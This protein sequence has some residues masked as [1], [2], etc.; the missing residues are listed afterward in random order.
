MSLKQ[1]YFESHCLW[2]CPLPD[3]HAARHRPSQSHRALGMAAVC[4]QGVRT[5]PLGAPTV[6]WL[7]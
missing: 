7:G 2:K 5:L 1:C 6:R 4:V 3:P